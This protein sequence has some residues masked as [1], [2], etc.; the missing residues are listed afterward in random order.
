MAMLCSPWLHTADEIDSL[1]LSFNDFALHDATLDLLQVLQTS[2]MANQDLQ[3]LAGKLTQQRAQLRAQE[4]EYRKLALVA[5][6]TDNAVVVTDAKGRVEWVNDGF[7]RM[8][9][10]TL[11][12]VKGRTP[13]KMLQGEETDPKLVDYMRQQIIEGKGFRAEIA[14]YH[15]DGTRYWVSLE[16]QPIHD[17]EGRVVNFMAIERDV[18]ERRNNERRR[19]LSFNVSRI[20]NDADTVRQA[21]ARICQDVCLRLGW[22]TGAVW[23][24]N[25]KG[26]QLE[27]ADLWHDPSTDISA[28]A[29]K[30]RELTFKPGVG[31]L[32][33]AWETAQ[34]VWIPDL[35]TDPNCPRTDEAAKV[36]LH[37]SLAVPILNKGQ[38]IGV[39]EFSSRRIE[40]QDESILQTM[41]GIGS[42]VGQ[43]F[44]RKQV[45]ADMAKAREEAE[46]ADKA[47]SE[48]LATMSHEIRT[49]MNGIIGMS[50]LLLDTP[51]STVQR[52]M[53][54][55][56]H[57]SGEALVT[58][59]DDILDFSKIEARRLDL[60]D[61]VFSVD[62]V[63]DGVVDLLSHKVQAKGLEMS[64]LIASDVPT[65]LT[66]DPGRLRQIL[67][68]LVGN[69]IKF[70]DEGQ[71]NIHVHRI[72]NPEDGAHRI[73]FMVED[74]GIGMTPVQLGQLFQAFT[75]VDGSSTR[76]FGGTGL[77]LV[78][79]KR[80]VEMMGG[81]LTVESE[82]HCGSKFRFNLPLRL[83]LNADASFL[84]P[85]ATRDYRVLIADPIG[86]SAQ[87][88]KAAFD[89]LHHP[90][91]IMEREASVVSA[92]HD[93]KLLWDVLVIDRRLFGSRTM[94]A[95]KQ[96]AKERRKPRVIVLG[97]LT[98]S[99]RERSSLSGVDLFLT[100]PPRRMQLRN[101][102]RNFSA[103]ETPNDKPA[104]AV[105]TSISDS[106]PRLLV[107]EDNEVNS[108]LATLLLEK[109]GF[110]SELARD[111]V[112]ALERFESTA[113]DGVLMDCHMP[114]M[115]GYEAT[116]Q[117]RL[118]EASA[119]WDRPPVRI[120]AMTANAMAGERERCIAAGMDDYLSKPLR[121]DPLMT[122]LSKITSQEYSD[123]STSESAWT[124]KDATDALQSIRQLAEEL[125]NEAAAQLLANWLDDTPKRLEEIMSLAG[126]GDQPTLRR[127]AHSLKGSSALFGLVSIQQLSRELEQLAEL[128]KPQGQTP[129]A[130]RL[131]IAFEAAE[132]ALRSELERLQ[133]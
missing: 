131:M 44:M 40:L 21:S 123:L 58:I 62:S 37:G 4:A 30:S 80:L 67:L 55:A 75:Q 11:D 126:G 109:L 116:R 101:A 28:F 121:A 95:L 99:V 20:L 7:V 16:V 32:G 104:G 69:A 24:L 82:R 54:E 12:E 113:Y 111:G 96:L 38:V 83:A 15:K 34:S 60:T 129:V 86:L 66:G 56:V 41:K 51:L 102:L 108:R 105:A 64:V 63:I 117:I 76:R 132:P 107:V 42:Q 3:K 125:S 31:M 33:K 52:E 39:F 29:L 1:G 103:P 71:V 25:D 88:S 98:D 93:P 120:I 91:V 127:A 22:V 48:F 53:V 57:T 72:K 85:E 68:N 119:D 78:I 118:L 2:Q 49:P 10:F 5:S 89:G 70:T 59:I 65:S 115:D 18:T 122:A 46:A 87:A 128:E 43:F 124:T 110:T 77:G 81:I 74:T 23:L 45:E 50:G 94:E 112:E 17:D 36:N 133:G 130:T 114:R 97:Q 90:P 61:E 84:W 19:S 92:L 35:A 6:R 106:S 100:K 73:E 14:N 27:L 47:K 8:T 13:G 9:G 26:E 79:S